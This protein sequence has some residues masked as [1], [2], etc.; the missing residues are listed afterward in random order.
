VVEVFFNELP[1]MPRLCR[2]EVV[3]VAPTSPS[4]IILAGSSDNYGLRDLSGLSFVSQDQATNDGLLREIE[5]STRANGDSLHAFSFAA[6]YLNDN[7]R[8]RC[9]RCD[10]ALYQLQRPGPSHKP[11]AMPPSASGLL[12]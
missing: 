12:V 4:T 11:L 9:V 1:F 2:L 8:I 7:A 6:K 5:A 10:P 3:H